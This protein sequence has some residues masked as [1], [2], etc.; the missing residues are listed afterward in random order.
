[1]EK[2]NNSNALTLQMSLNVAGC[3]HSMYFIWLHGT[4]M[5]AAALNS[6][7]I[8]EAS[9]IVSLWHCFCCHICH[10]FVSDSPL[11]PPSSTFKNPCDGTSL[12]VPWLRLRLPIQGLWVQSLVGEL[13]S[14]MACG[15]TTKTLKKQRQYC[16]KFNNDFKNGPHTKKILKGLP[17]WRSG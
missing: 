5:I 9:N 14:H 2:I 10:I 12:A 1:M 8:F 3:H 15:Q 6:S 17:W 13:R 4:I 16:D 11:L 7:S